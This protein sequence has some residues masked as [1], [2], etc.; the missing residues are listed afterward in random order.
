[1]TMTAKSIDQPVTRH[2]DQKRAKLLEALESPSRFAQ[3]IDQVGP[4]RLHDVGRIELRSQRAGN[5]AMNRHPHVRLKG[6]EHLLDGALVARIES[7]ENRVERIV[8]H[9]L[10][11]RSAF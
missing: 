2:L 8:H 4:D 11:R 3:A 9:S 10:R 6:D 7:N 5:A 1:M